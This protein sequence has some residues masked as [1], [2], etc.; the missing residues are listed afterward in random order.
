MKRIFSLFLL[1]ICLC[2]CSFQKKTDSDT[3]T[4]YYLKENYTYG[5]NGTAVATEPHEKGSA[6]W[7]L[8]YLITMYLMGPVED[9]HISPLPPGTRIECSVNQDHSIVL[10]LSDN[11]KILSDAEFSLACACLSLTCFDVTDAPAVTVLDGER[12]VTLHADTIFLTDDITD[13]LNTEAME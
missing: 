7:D 8:P 13:F 10:E 6:T 1:L 3:V 2:G 12:I 4:F 11:V 5:Q 9:G